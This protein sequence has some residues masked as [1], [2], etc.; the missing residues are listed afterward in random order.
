MREA[1]TRRDGFPRFL[2]VAFA[3]PSLVSHETFC[4]LGETRVVSMSEW[5]APT[6]S[7]LWRY[8]LQYFDDL[9]ALGATKR[10]E[11][12]VYLLEKWL[13]AALPASHIGWAPYPLSL[14][15]SNWTKWLSKNPDRA[16][17]AILLSLAQQADVL[18]QRLE[19]H[20]LGNHLLENA[21]ALVLVGAYLAGRDADR[22]LTT[23]LHI[24]DIEL[25]EQFLDDGGHFELT[26]MYQ[27]TILWGLLD[28]IELGMNHPHLE[29]QRRCPSWKRLFQRGIYWL[30]VMTHPDQE[31]AFFNDAAFGIAPSAT[32]LRERAMRMKMDLPRSFSPHRQAA[33]KLT[34]LSS[35]G[36]ARVDWAEAVLIT[37]MA[38]VGPDYIPGHGHADTLS[39]EFSLKSNRVFVNSGTS[40]YGTSSER[41][42]QR[43]TAAHNT[44][45]VDGKDSSEVWAGFRV[46]RRAYP[47]G[48]CAIVD[49]N[50]A[51]LACSHSGYLRLRG[52][53]RHERTWICSTGQLQ[54][55]D[56]LHGKFESGTAYLLVHPDWNVTECNDH[57]AVLHHPDGLSLSVHV[58]GGELRADA[59]TWHPRFGDTVST[60]RLTTIF[61]SASVRYSIRWS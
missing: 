11:E 54:I 40:C 43:S 35:S 16:S 57:S 58:Q 5:D 9:N 47:E 27:A 13:A 20:L 48:A 34:H 59:G 38:R 14:R 30:E 60:T 24:L 4:F 32:V 28:L 12:H 41:Q 61:S 7:Q 36:Y 17:P 8:N 2:D 56:N 51:L 26:P 1:P 33:P 10:V 49:E 37:D 19:Y 18:E 6:C 39:F 53:V 22:W 44:V 3:E 23:G 55:Q 46:A 52:R 45:A 42:R 21:R 50:H 29:F 15:V 25:K 31:I